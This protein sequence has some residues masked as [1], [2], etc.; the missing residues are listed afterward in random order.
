MRVY[1]IHARVIVLCVFGEKTELKA[2]LVGLSLS[3]IGNVKS[4]RQVN[5]LVDY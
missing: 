4:E 3:N 5:Y 1:R 2:E